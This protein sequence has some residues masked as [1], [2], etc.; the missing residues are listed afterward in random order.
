MDNRLSQI[1]RRRRHGR[2][3]EVELCWA[4]PRS[5]RELSVYGVEGK[6]ERIGS[7]LGK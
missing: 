3:L 4:C 5:I 2:A 6:K 7:E 1:D